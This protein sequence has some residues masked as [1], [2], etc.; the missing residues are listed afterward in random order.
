VT[1]QAMPRGTEVGSKKIFIQMISSKINLHLKNYWLEKVWNGIIY[2]RSYN[3][4]QKH[5]LII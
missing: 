1:Q 5:L 3:T 4:S 2:G